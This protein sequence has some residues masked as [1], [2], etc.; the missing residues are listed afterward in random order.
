MSIF[1][2]IIW[3]VLFLT[4]GLPVLGGLLIVAAMGASS[5]PN[6]LLEYSLWTDAQKDINQKTFGGIFD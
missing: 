1:K 3:L 6:S 5:G 4:F 2:S